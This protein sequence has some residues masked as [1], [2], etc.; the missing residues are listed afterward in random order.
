M[1]RA[2][3]GEVEF[4][5]IESENPKDSVTITDKPV[6]IGQDVSDHVKQNPSTI[7]IPGQMVGDDA[8]DKLKMLQ[9]YQ[10]E[11][12]LLKYIGRNMYDNM[13]IEDIDRVH[14]VA[15]RFGFGF[16]I[17][18]KHIR[19]AT[20]KTVEIKVT[21]PKTK[22]SSKKTST[23]V[24]PTTNNGKQQPAAKKPMPETYPN[25]P[26]LTKKSHFKPAN[27]LGNMN[28]TMSTFKNYGAPTTGRG[29]S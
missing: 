20:A 4:S 2:K 26:V 17:K 23:K 11:G 27:T 21:N 6:E 29:K 13:A 3:L 19:I 22:K 25:S 10:K 1:R 28:R 18:L 14:P 9:K 8:S 16:T 12:T 5:V 24:K 15:N 7:S